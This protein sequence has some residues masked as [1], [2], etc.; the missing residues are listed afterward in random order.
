MAKGSASGTKA[1][2]WNRCTKAFG[3]T[4]S[5]KV[6]AVCDLGAEAIYTAARL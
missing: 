2:K 5:P 1:L 6:R 4:E 3:K